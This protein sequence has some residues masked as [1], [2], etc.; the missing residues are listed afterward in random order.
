MGDR[1]SWKGVVITVGHQEVVPGQVV[2]VRL[3]DGAA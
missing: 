2:D 3:A 1:S